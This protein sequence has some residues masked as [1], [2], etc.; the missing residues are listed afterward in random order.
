MVVLCFLIELMATFC[1][2]FVWLLCGR[3]IFKS[4]ISIFKIVVASSFYVVVITYLNSIELVSQFTM[5]VCM[6]IYGILM[7]LL[8]NKNIVSAL[9]VGSTCM[10]LQLSIEMLVICLFGLATNDPN[11]I[12]HI[13]SSSNLY[14][15]EYV[16]FLKVLMF[17]LYFLARKVFDKID[18][19]LFKNP[20]YI[21]FDIAAILLVL[22]VSTTI[23]KNNLRDTKIAIALMF[24]FFL[25]IIGLIVYLAN[26]LAKKQLQLRESS[27]IQLK[28]DILEKDLKNINKLYS[29]NSKS[30]HEFKHHLDII[31]IMLDNGQYDNMKEY[32]ANLKPTDRYRPEFVTENSIVNMVMNVKCNDMKEKGIDFDY[33]VGNLS[34]ININNDDFCSLLA[35]LMDNAIEAVEKTDNGKIDFRLSAP[36]DF[37]VI[38]VSNSCDGV[39]TDDLKSTKTGNHGWGLKIIDDVVKKYCGVI[40]RVYENNMFVTKIMLPFKSKNSY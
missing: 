17:V 27:Y 19:T 6:F 30:F 35:N 11:Y 8:Y 18:Y 32:I 37:V 34:S 9:A 23:E 22:T 12:L 3:R 33:N 25:L 13:L 26:T 15:I 14:R 7:Y 5:F 31:K 36:A 10:V 2:V 39:D 16:V 21:V 38:T 28:N 1:E 40:E 4:D 20:V 29:E 24:V